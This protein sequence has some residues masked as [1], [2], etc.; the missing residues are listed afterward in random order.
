[1]T[2]ACADP[3][4]ATALAIEAFTK[5]EFADESQVG[6]WFDLQRIKKPSLFE[7]PEANGAGH[8][9]HTAHVGRFGTLGAQGA[10]AMLTSGQPHM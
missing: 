8:D 4:H 7:A 6:A 3:V 5:G 1:V 9:R 10:L 2:A